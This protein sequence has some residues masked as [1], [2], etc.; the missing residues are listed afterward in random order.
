M[1]LKI[2]RDFRFPGDCVAS[3]NL[4]E[5]AEALTHGMAPALFGGF[6]EAR[7]AQELAVAREAH[8]V[9]Q[10]FAVCVA[11]VRHGAE[12]HELEDFFIFTG[13]GLRKE[14]V[15]LHLHGANEREH[16]KQRAQAHDGSKCTEE[17]QD[18]FEE[19]LV[20]TPKKN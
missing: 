13:A 5:S 19:V 11:F 17:I 6:I 9:G 10:E 2:V 7:A 15:A 3:V 8:V 20:H 16:N 1:I 12:L 18:A 4:R 14:G